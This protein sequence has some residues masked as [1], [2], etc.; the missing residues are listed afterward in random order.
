MQ[1]LNYYLIKLISM[2]K[3]AVSKKLLNK[4]SKEKHYELK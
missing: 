3:P 2:R 1:F 4:N